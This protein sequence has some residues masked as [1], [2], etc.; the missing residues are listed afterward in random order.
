MI[1]D[2]DHDASLD[3]IR[4]RFISDVDIIIAEG[5]KRNGSPR[6]RSSGQAMQAEPLCK[7]MDRR[8][9][10]RDGRSAGNRRSLPGA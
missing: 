9:R 5:F 4:D 10:D 1:R 7:T 8:Y 3:E 6:S 2:M